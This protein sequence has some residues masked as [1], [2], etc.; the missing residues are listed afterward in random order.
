MV[1]KNQPLDADVTEETNDEVDIIDKKQEPD[2]S[3]EVTD[4]KSEDIES[5]DS[6]D[7]EEDDEIEATDE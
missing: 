7:E 2:T 5:S 4:V 1:D 6:E 3:G